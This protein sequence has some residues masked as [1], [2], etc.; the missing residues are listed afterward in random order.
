MN[1]PLRSAEFAPYRPIREGVQFRSN[2]VKRRMVWATS[3]APIAPEAPD[4]ISAVFNAKENLQKV[5][6]TILESAAVKSESILLAEQA[7]LRQSGA[8]ERDRLSVS[9]DSLALDLSKILD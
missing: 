9:I 4:D 2:F 1:R 7:L 5:R 3:H 8:A 6:S